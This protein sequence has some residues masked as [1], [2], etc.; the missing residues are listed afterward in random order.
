MKRH[1]KAGDGGGLGFTGVVGVAGCRGGRKKE[2][3]KRDIDE[4]ANWR[5]EGFLFSDMV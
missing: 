1:D 2:R 5:G 4:C 3:Q